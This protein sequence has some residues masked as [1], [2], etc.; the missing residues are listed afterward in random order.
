MGERGLYM[1]QELQKPNMWKRISAALLDFVL[2]FVVIEGLILLLTAVLGYNSYVDR[3]NEIE[4]KYI[5]DYGIVRDMTEAEL[6]AMPE[7][8]Q[9]AY[10]AKVEAAN[11]A[12]QTDEEVIW[13]FGKI[14]NI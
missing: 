13:L 6:N 8:E 4:A 10:K 5:A 9:T 12:Y 7:A 3:R 2:I 11:R 1:Y 14:M